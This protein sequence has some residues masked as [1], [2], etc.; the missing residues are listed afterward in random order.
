VHLDTSVEGFDTDDDGAVRAVVT[1][2]GTYPA[3]VVVL[4]L[5]VHPASGLA[6]DAGV[7]VGPTGGIATD[8]RMSTSADG[9]WAAGDCVE[10][11]HRISQKP[12]AIALGT[13]ANKQ[14]KVVGVNVTG[15]YAAFP[16]VIGTAVT[17]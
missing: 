12:V 8:R 1:K 9:V 4:G 16:G 10:T 7:D 11:F 2:T 13:H 14:G 6:K 5:G 17:K 15:G 3:D